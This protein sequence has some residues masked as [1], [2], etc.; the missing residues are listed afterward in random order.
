MNEFISD[1]KYM[2]RADTGRKFIPVVADEVKNYL[3]ILSLYKGTLHKI[4]GILI[5]YVFWKQGC[6]NSLIS[7]EN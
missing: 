3:V 5:I 6:L 2:H 4:G 7:D 1:V